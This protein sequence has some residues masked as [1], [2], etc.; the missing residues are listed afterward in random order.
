VVLRRL[1][2]KGEL[3]FRDQTPPPVAGRPAV[4]AYAATQP[5]DPAIRAAATAL[6]EWLTSYSGVFVKPDGWPGRN[7]SDAYRLVTG[8]YLPGDPREG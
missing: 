3:A 7:T 2:E 1:A 4:V 6:Q 5:A 8:H